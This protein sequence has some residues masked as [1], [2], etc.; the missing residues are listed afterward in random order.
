LVF[1]GKLSWFWRGLERS[2]EKG[3][4]RGRR[5]VMMDEGGRKLNNGF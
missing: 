4:G 5:R 2:V 1:G 3:F